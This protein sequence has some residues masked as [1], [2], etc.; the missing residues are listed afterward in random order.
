M[1]QTG[2][3]KQSQM[4]SK[5]SP[6]KSSKMNVEYTTVKTV[7]GSTQKNSGSAEFELT[8]L[9]PKLVESFLSTVSEIPLPNS[10]STASAKSS[11]EAVDE[12]DSSS[13]SSSDSSSESSS[14]SSSDSSNSS[15]DSSSENEEEENKHPSTEQEE[16]VLPTEM[17]TNIEADILESLDCEDEKEYKLCGTFLVNDELQSPRR[18]ITMIDQHTNAILY[19]SIFYLLETTMISIQGYTLPL[20]DFLNVSMIQSSIV[21]K[22]DT[23]EKYQIL[24]LLLKNTCYISFTNIE[25]SMFI[26]FIQYISKHHELPDEWSE[27]TLEE[28]ESHSISNKEIYDGLY[29]FVIIPLS[30]IIYFGVILYIYILMNNI[31]LMRTA[32]I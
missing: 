20:S 29:R 18:H 28:E 25:E 7:N 1:T 13:E 5:S 16:T 22:E 9:L 8:T 32:N 3:L 27:D 26:E 12:S 21:E 17:D 19:C 15:S 2:A 6:S 10:E 24:Y 14:E 4:S 31:N 11:E 23:A 30:M